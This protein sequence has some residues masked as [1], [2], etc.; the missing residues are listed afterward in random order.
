M[1]QSRSTRNSIVK[2]SFEQ[3]LVRKARLK[4][5]TK[6]KIITG[7]MEPFIH[8]GEIVECSPQPYSELEIGTPIIFWSEEKLICHFLMEKYTKENK[9]F[10]VTKGLNSLKAD[11]ENTPDFYFG[12][13]TNPKISKFKRKLFNFLSLFSKKDEIEK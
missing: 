6:V 5:N 1:M 10:F 3:F 12:V 2:I 4:P 8:A 13:V 11:K 7:S 9:E